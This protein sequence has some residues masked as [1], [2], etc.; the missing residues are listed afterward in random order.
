MFGPHAAENLAAF[1][2]AGGFA[3]Q[4]AQVIEFRA[5]DLAGSNHV[6]VV[7]DPG[8][9]REDALHAMAEADFPHRDRLTHPGIVTG[10]QRSLER[11][12]PLL[13]AFLDP[14]VHTNRIAGA[15]FGNIGAFVLVYEFSQQR[16]IHWPT[17]LFILSAPSQDRSITVAAQKLS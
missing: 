9:Q 13:I 8:V 14:D 7:D 15:K 6:D 4:P 3:P 1:F 16:V 17:S 5:P 10:D 12:Q 2:Q 11:L